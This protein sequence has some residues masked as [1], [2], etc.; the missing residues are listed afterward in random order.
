MYPKRTGRPF[1]LEIS[2]WLLLDQARDE[3]VQILRP[4]WTSIELLAQT[5][6]SFAS[7]ALTLSQG[8]DAAKTV[9]ETA[10]SLSAF[11]TIPGYDGGGSTAGTTIASAMV[12]AA[13]QAGAIIANRRQSGSWDLR[14][15]GQLLTRS[16][17]RTDEPR[18]RAALRAA[19]GTN[20]SGIE[21]CAVCGPWSD[22]YPPGDVR[23]VA[24][25]R[26]A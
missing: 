8:V 9:F 12:G 3:L 19:S 11:V 1:V 22:Q 7:S 10:P 14:P 5:N 20:V 21:P 18:T 24:A 26:A 13:G 4:P 25:F 15:S 2:D 17:L 23:G 16:G 6:N